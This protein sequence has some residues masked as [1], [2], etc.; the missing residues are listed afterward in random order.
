MCGQRT[1]KLTKISFTFLQISHL[2]S[3]RRV[4]NL[5]FYF[6][7]TTP[8]RKLTHRTKFEH[9]ER[10]EF[11]KHHNSSL[12]WAREMPKSYP[13]RHEFWKCHVSLPPWAREMPKSYP[14]RHEFRKHHNSSLPWARE[15]PKS[16]PERHKF[17][18]RHVSSPPWARE[19]PKSYPERHEFWK[20]HV[21]SPPWAREMPKR[22]AQKDT[23]FGNA[24]ILHYLGPENH[25]IQP[26]N[27][28]I[29]HKTALIDP[30]KNAKESIHFSR[31]S[32]IV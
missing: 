12:P 2:S 1:P 16:Y 18:K 19:M 25:Q 31:I 8:A 27:T 13:E 5:T 10:H 30:S 21:S 28:R 29:S 7:F 6:Q 4:C 17:W 15:M 24:I 14:E 32:H 23:N 20:R 11:R 26:Q 9:A 22:Q 3:N